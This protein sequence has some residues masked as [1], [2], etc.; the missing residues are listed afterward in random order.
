MPQR[1]RQ[2]RQEQLNRYDL[3]SIFEDIRNRL[4]DIVE[5]EREGIG[6]RLE[7]AEQ[8]LADAERSSPSSEQGGQQASGQDSETGGSGESGG[9]GEAGI[10][11]DQERALT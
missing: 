11:L 3:G 4:Q 7:E 9:S 8:R 10:D 5:A 2:Q 1:A 6:D